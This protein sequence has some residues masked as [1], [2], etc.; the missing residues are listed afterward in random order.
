MRKGKGINDQIKKFQAL[1]DAKV[2]VDQ[3]LEELMTLLESSD[4]DSDSVGKIQD[5]FT[6]A[7]ERK[8]MS[9]EN[10]EEFKRLDSQSLSRMEKANDLEKLLSMYKID[11]NDTKKLVNNDKGS[12]LA[13]LIVG[14][15][16]I[17]LG[18]AM[19]ILPAPPYF[20]LFTIFYF[21]KND[22][23]T[24]MDLIALIIA[25]TGVYLSVNSLAK[26]KRL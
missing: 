2:S 17:V 22:G 18:F 8:R 5:K 25:F 24:L 10:L 19:I 23:V 4:L 21:T 15:L 7:V 14:I 1:D 13:I 20:E 6:K 16:M 26:L 3:K 12:C 11:S 9:I